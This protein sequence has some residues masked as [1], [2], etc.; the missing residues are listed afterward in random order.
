M[1]TLTNK[2]NQLINR[3]TPITG[4]INFSQRSKV[5]LQRDSMAISPPNAGFMRFETPSPI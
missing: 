1:A 3:I 5:T 4:S 2:Y